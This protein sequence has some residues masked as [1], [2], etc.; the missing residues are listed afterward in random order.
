M[1][2]GHDYEHDIVYASTWVR[3]RAI[4]TLTR[5]T[6]TII[7]TWI[8]QS[9][10]SFGFLGSI[11]SNT[12]SPDLGWDT[13][14]FPMDIRHTTLVMKVKKSHSSLPTKCVTSLCYCRRFW[15]RVGL[16]RVAS[17]STAKFGV[18]RPTWGICSL[19]TSVR[20]HTCAFHLMHAP[21]TL[22]CKRYLYNL[23]TLLAGAM[24]AFARGLK[25]AAKLVQEG[26]LAKHVQ[27][28]P[29]LDLYIVTHLFPCCVLV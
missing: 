10:C 20:R 19:R 3:M 13:D 23:Q 24:D 12:G 5:V 27:V 21:L 29:W 18:S 9:C 17:I 7:R 8:N 22:S 11:D 16:R 25:I 26:V 1:L 4:T 15:S 2:A 28:W 14:Q 6:N